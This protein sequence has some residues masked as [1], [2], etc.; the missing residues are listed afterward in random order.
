MTKML[1]ALMFLIGLKPNPPLDLPKQSE[2]CIDSI[3]HLD[4]TNARAVSSFN[5]AVRYEESSVALSVSYQLNPGQVAAGSLSVRYQ[6]QTITGTWWDYGTFTFYGL[7][8]Q[9][10]VEQTLWF[11]NKPVKFIF[12]GMNGPFCTVTCQPGPSTSCP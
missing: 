8:V 12:T 11:D 10:N 9:R 2:K 4:S 5:L 3:R 1:L 7:P 6:S